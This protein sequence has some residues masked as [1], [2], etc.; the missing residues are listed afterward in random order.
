M[1]ALVKRL[2]L[3]GITAAVCGWLG[4]AWASGE[5]LTLSI[6]PAK[7]PSPATATI[8][9][10]SATPDMESFSLELNF[11]GGTILSLKTPLI[12]VTTWFTR[13][14]YFPPRPFTPY[15]TDLNNINVVTAGN[16]VFINGFKPNEA[17]GKIGTVTFKVNALALDGDTQT[18]TLSGKFY[19]TSRQIVSFAPVTKVF[20]VGVPPTN[21]LTVTIGG[22]GS[23]QVNSDIAG[24][25]KSINCTSGT[26]SATYSTGTDVQL[27]ATISNGSDFAGWSGACS[28]FG[29]TSPCKV[30]VDADKTTTAS[31]TA[32]GPY[33][34]LMGPP[35]QPFSLLQQA[36]DTALTGMVIKAQATVLTE[37]L[38]L[39]SPILVIIKGG[40]GSDF[41]VQNGMTTVK[42]T[43]TISQG[44][45]VVD[46][47]VIK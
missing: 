7:A 45:L 11:A 34:Q 8:G 2:I 37:T 4:T 47:L 15:A 16:K 25:D 24:I 29:K 44:S 1:K 10:T 20:T 21:T 46:R 13:D 17:S 36:Y 30:T 39:N 28:S 35:V 22:S 12:P 31:F 38:I 3:A 41:S 23:G 18:V 14:T 43:L 5:A 27:F 6:A 26:C 19:S 32:A 33:V 42:G 9:I 40:Y